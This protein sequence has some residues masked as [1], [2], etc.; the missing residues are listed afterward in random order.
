[1]NDDIEF[2]ELAA[3]SPRRRLPCDEGCGKLGKW[4][5]IPQTQLAKSLMGTLLL[6]DDDKVA[7]EETGG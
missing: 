4:E 6:C 3:D 7:L 1:M 2:R 5:A